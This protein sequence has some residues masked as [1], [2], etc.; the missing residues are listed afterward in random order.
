MPR[1]PSIDHSTLLRRKRRTRTAGQY[2]S[3]LAMTYGDVRPDPPPR[4]RGRTLLTLL[5][6]AALIGLGLVVSLKEP[7]VLL[8][9][10]HVLLHALGY[11]PSGPG[12]VALV[13]AGRPL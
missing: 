5:F 4:G 8:I 7:N 13:A 1:H 11:D 12:A 2:H 9:R 3:M 6:L 10:L